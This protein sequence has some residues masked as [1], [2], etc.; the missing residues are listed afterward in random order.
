[1]AIAAKARHA[2]RQYAPWITRTL[3]MRMC[4]IDYP[5][6]SRQLICNH[7]YLS[8]HARPSKAWVRHWTA[9]AVFVDVF[10]LRQRYTLADID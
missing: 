3:K 2:T 10:I 8:G 6:N 7:Q 4:L 5:A 1:M 9:R